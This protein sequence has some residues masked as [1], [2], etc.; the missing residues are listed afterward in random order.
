MEVRQARYLKASL[1]ALQHAVN[2]IAQRPP[3]VSP[4]SKAVLVNEKHILLKAS[5]EMW[6]K[7]QLPNDR[8]MVAVNVCINAV[9]ALENL[10]DQGRER[11]GEW[12]TW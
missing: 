7:S 3:V 1:V 11:L 2:Q 4:A 8:V 6:L 12:D 9:H 10:A 5:V